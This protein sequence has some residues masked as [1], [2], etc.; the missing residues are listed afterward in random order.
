MARYQRFVQVLNDIPKVCI[1]PDMPMNGLTCL[2]AGV[3]AAT[4][5]MPSLLPATI[6][7]QAAAR[8]LHRTIERN[9]GPGGL[10]R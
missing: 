3:S 1:L 2:S 10:P 7:R 6:W 5:E 4:G 8:P 9:S